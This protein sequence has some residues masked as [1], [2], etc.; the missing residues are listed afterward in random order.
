MRFEILGR[1]STLNVTQFFFFIEWR[2]ELTLADLQLALAVLQCGQCSLCL[3]QH[4]P[5]ESMHSS[6]GFMVYFLPA[7]KQEKG[8]LFTHTIMPAIL[9]HYSF[10]TSD[11]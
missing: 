1:P 3:R 5:H 4:R 8:K 11:R 10:M 9:L 6:N 2:Q 7:N